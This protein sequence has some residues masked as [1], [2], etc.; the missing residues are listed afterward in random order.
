LRERERAYVVARLGGGP[1]VFAVGHASCVCAGVV[2]R[3][4][5]LAH[6][7]RGEEARANFLEYGHPHVNRKS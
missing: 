3:A 6:V 5:A 7:R 2:A 1:R 4:A